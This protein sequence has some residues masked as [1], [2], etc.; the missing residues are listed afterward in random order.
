[1][2]NK[3]DEVPIQGSLLSPE[4]SQEAKALQWAGVWTGLVA[5]HN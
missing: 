2:D 5:K 1:M 3:E 4:K